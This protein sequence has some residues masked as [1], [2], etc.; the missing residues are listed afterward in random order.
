MIVLGVYFLQPMAVK[1]MFAMILSK[2]CFHSNEFDEMP[3][4]LDSSKNPRSFE[5]YPTLPWQIKSHTPLID[6][7]FVTS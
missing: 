6:V 1:I 4:A 2:F 7:A 5:K 3:C